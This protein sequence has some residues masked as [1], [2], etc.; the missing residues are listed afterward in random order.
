MQDLAEAAITPAYAG[1]VVP[2]FARGAP[3]D[4]LSLVL[5][6]WDGRITLVDDENR[7]GLRCRGRP[8]RPRSSLRGRDRV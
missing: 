6:D 4:A 1:I 3:V 8:L 7:L 5:W 2:I